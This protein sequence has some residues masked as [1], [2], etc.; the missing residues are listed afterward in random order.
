ML[1]GLPRPVEGK[2]VCIS[3]VLKACYLS[4]TESM[5]CKPF[6]GKSVFAAGNGKQ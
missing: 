6:T 4:K 5:Q 3:L 1:L 2:A